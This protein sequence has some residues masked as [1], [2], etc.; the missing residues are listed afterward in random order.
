RSGAARSQFQGGDAPEGT[1]H[2]KEFLLPVPFC[3][4]LSYRFINNR[5][6]L[7]HVR[8]SRLAA[9]FPISPVIGNG[10]VDS[11]PVVTWSDLVIV[12]GYFAVSMKEQDPGTAFLAI[13]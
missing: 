4:S 2:D 9:A 3:Q 6:I 1:P 5:G 12:C 10:Q 7:N 13:V 11:L 8:K